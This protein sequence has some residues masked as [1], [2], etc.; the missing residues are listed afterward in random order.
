MLKINL[1]TVNIYIKCL[2][3]NTIATINN[4]DNKTL[5]TISTG[6]IGFKGAKRATRHAAQELLK[7]LKT[8]LLSKKYTNL[9]LYISGFGKGRPVLLKTLKH[10]FLKILK[11]ID[12]SNKKHNGCKLKKKR[13]I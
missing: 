8:F 6:H 4:N 3:N 12:I 2:K 11:I 9:N 10:P 7:T 1:K 5:I 13:R